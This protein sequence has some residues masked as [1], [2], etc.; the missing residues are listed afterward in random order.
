MFVMWSAVISQRTLFFTFDDVTIGRDLFISTY[1]KF[2]CTLF[3]LPS[4]VLKL[5][6]AS[7]KIKW[8][9]LLGCYHQKFIL[10]D[11]T[12]DLC[13]SSQNEGGT[14]ERP[15]HWGTKKIR[16]FSLTETCSSANQH[17]MK[18]CASTFLYK[19]DRFIL[20]N[21]TRICDCDYDHFSIFVA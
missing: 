19:M 7:T 6:S 8:V 10:F 3:F 5:Y 16:V 13:T 9:A 11:W 12:T 2:D 1:S 18:R 15:H 17:L 21:W 20:Y 14:R 4:T